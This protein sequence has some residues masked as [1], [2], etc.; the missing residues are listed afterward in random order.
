[1]GLEH[2]W[3]R[4]LSD[5]LIRADQVVGIRAHRSPEM[6]GKPSRWLVTAALAVAAGSGTRDEWDIADLHRTLTQTDWEPR[7]APEMLAQTLNRLDDSGAAG[8][9]RPV[10]DHGEIRFEFTPF[11]DTD[12]NNV[13]VSADELK[14]HIT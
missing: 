13:P 5:G 8:I 11:D 4:T 12:T 3:I 7:H 9:V 10:P 14:V 6:V 2:V 1:M